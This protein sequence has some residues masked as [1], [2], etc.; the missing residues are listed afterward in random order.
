M[1]EWIKMKLKKLMLMAALAAAIGSVNMVTAFADENETETKYGWEGDGNTWRYYD[2]N[3]NLKSGWIKAEEGDGRGNEVWYYIDPATNLMI[4]NTTRTIDGVSYSFGEDGSW[5]APV[6]TAPKGHVT[7]GRYYNTWSNLCV[8]QIVGSTINDYE[9][10]D[11]YTGTDYASIGSP[12]L[13]HDL[14]MSTDFGD[15]EVYYLNMKNKPEMDAQT[16]ANS[17][18]GIEKGQ[19]G[20]STAAETVTIANQQYSK[21]TVTGKKTQRAFY[22]RK[23]GGYMVVIQTSGR[24]KDVA[25]LESIVMAMTTAQ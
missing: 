25:A 21:V 13:T 12:S 14:Y 16:F 24:I 8:P 20:Q 23:Q 17:L 7:G 6:Q 22:C 9:A 18:A 1:K 3:G 5:V 10:A 15:V 11:Q 4:Y 19:K 2:A